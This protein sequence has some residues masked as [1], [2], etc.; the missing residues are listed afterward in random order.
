MGLPAFVLSHSLVHAQLFNMETT[1]LWDSISNAMGVDV[2]FLF[3]QSLGID[4]FFLSSFLSLPMPSL[5]P[6]LSLSFIGVRSQT[7][8]LP[9][10]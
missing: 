2:K 4:F 10:V 8:G 7:Q 9:R 5:C 1:D 3:C 6:F